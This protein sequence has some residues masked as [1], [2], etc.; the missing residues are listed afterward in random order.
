MTRIVVLDTETTGEDPA[1]GA[2]VCEYAHSIVSVGPNGWYDGPIVEWLCN[3][4]HP[5]PPEMSAI[6][7]LRDADVE[8]CPTFAESAATRDWSKVTHYCAHN[9]KFDRAFVGSVLPERPWVCTW[10]CASVLWPEAPNHKNQTLRYWLNLD[11]VIKSGLAPH[12]AGY[13]VAVTAALLIRMLRERTLEDLVDISSRPILLST[14]H[15]GKH[16]GMR[17]ADLDSGYLRWV[18]RQDFDEDARHTARHW[19]D[20]R[21]SPAQSGLP[22]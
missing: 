13:D 16:K 5:I 14:V 22:L 21:F 12:R 17:W 4:G 15:F 20:Q 18:L 19:L 11:V 1:A 10:R 7:H 6:H 8:G 2:A 9:A 3:P